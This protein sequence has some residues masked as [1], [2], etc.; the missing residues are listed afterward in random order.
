[1]SF[2]IFVIWHFVINHFVIWHFV[3]W[4]CVIN[5]LIVQ[6]HFVVQHIVIYH[7]IVQR[8]FVVRHFGPLQKTAPSMRAFCLWMISSIKFRW[9][10]YLSSRRS[11]RRTSCCCSR[12][13]LCISTWDRFYKTP[14]PPK[15]SRTNCHPQILDTFPNLKQCWI[16][17]KKCRF[18]YKT[19]CISYDVH[20]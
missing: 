13:S 2:D 5:H 19:S 11:R 15:T 6:W 12:A 14:F 18:L 3:N 1:L 16:N 8:H 20:M 10:S 7:L 9:R 17:L 4:Q